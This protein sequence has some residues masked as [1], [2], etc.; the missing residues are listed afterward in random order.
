MER[1]G[2]SGGLPSYD[3]AALRARSERLCYGGV[4]MISRILAPSVLFAPALLGSM[5]EAQSVAPGFRM[6]G[7][8]GTGSS[9]LIDNT[10]TTVHTWTSGFNPGNAMYL[11]AD[12]TLIRTKQTAGNPGIGGSGGGAQRLA[13]DSTLLWDFNYDGPDV[14]H[15]HDIEPLPSGNILFIA[16]DKLTRTDA[17]AL[18]RNPGTISGSAWLPDSIVEVQQTG[19]TTGNIVWEWHATDH[20]I[21]DFSSGLPN[22][23][24]VADHP[25]R[26]DINYPP[27][28]LSNGDW[29]HCNSI[30]YDPTRDLVFLN[31]PFIDEF[32]VIDH[33]TTTVEAAGSTGG[34]FGK[35]G[36]LVY[37]YGN[38]V[39][40]GAGLASAQT[41]FNQHGTS[42]IPEGL[43]GAGNILLFNNQAGTPLSLNFSTVL[44]LELPAT[45]DLLPGGAFPQAT[46]VYSYNAPNPT[47]LYSAGLSNAERLPN[48]NTLVCSGRQNGWLFEL[49]PSQQIVWEFFNTFPSPN[50]IVFQVSYYERMLWADT[51]EL[52]VSA[53]GTVDFDLVG[54]SPR[55][56]ELYWLFGS[57]TGTAPGITSAGVTLP[58][59]FDSYF[60]YTI[61]SANSG[62]LQNTFQSLDALGN[63]SATLSV[64]GGVAAALVGTTLNHSFV[65][66][67]AATG[68]PLAASNAVPLELVP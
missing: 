47:D 28:N 62:V 5:A 25:E 40:Y 66:L 60:L 34:T 48:G 12:G 20:L 42:V 55:A 61:N 65:T 32:Y 41:L 27:T 19:L 23:G 58:L 15:H 24:V 1:K 2:R 43:P 36:D 29:Q 33:S 26:I 46:E 68:A 49:E 38:P 18:G 31:T 59:N 17:I 44:E 52:S 37:R 14:W 21:Q 22:F 57:R 50:S 16:W 35:G 56:G 53:G 54:G 64:P 8:S 51:Q 9:F 30:S 10:G 11:E 13:F 7:P 3:G 45:F 6:Y 4:P 39:S 67:D 63:G